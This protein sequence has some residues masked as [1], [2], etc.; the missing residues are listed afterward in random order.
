MSHKANDEY[1]EQIRESAYEASFQKLKDRKEQDWE[2]HLGEK[3]SNWIK[4]RGDAR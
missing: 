1:L 2:K 4:E 3:V